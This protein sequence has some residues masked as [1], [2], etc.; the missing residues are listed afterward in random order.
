ME[1]PP[2]TADGE[3][4]LRPVSPWSFRELRDLWAYWELFWILAVRDVSVRYKQAVLGIAWALLQP[5]TQMVIFTVLFNRM[6]GIKGDAE[7]PY[8]V[9]CLSGLVVWQLFSNGLGHA[10]ES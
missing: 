5:A 1:A 6:A 2:K 3:L 10:S 8:P 4:V 9:F 7:I